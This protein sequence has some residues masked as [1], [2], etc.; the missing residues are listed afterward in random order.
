[1]GC[2]AGNVVSSESVSIFF[3]A[4]DS[5]AEATPSATDTLRI[6]RTSNQRV[7]ICRAPGSSLSLM[8]GRR[9]GCQSSTCLT[10]FAESAGMRIDSSLRSFIECHAIGRL[11]C[12]DGRQSSQGN[13][14]SSSAQGIVA[15]AICTS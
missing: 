9:S 14:P 1:L 15:P 6:A 12:L 4:T 5:P 2:G 3:H 11:T 10:F 7:S 8:P 13:A